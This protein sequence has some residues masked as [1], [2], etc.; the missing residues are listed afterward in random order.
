MNELFSFQNNLLNITDNGWH[1]YLYTELKK[2]T[3]L[4][5]LKGLR[6]VVNHLQ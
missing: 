1:R 3:R 4:H 5:S 2:D 6:G